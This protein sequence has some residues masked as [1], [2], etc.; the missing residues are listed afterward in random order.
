MLP[1]TF[2]QVWDDVDE[3]EQEGGGLPGAGLR[4]VYQ[5]PATQCGRNG[6]RLNGRAGVRMPMA[7]RPSNR[8]SPMPRS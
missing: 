1:S 8:S 3:R 6:L 2:G 5:V 7:S 4:G